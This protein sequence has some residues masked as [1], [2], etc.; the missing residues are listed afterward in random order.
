MF[1]K[2]VA[3]R[4]L[5][6]YR[7]R[8][9]RSRDA[10]PYFF[11]W[12]GWQRRILS[13]VHKQG[14]FAAAGAGPFAV[15]RL[16]RLF[17]D[18]SR[19]ILY[20]NVTNGS[21]MTTIWFPASE[22]NGGTPG[23]Y[24]NSREMLAWIELFQKYGFHWNAAQIAKLTN[25]YSYSFPEASIS[26]RPRKFPVVLYVHGQVG[27]RTDNTGLAEELASHGFIVV[28][29]AHGGTAGMELPDG[30]MVKPK[31]EFH[32]SGN[33]TNP[34]AR[35]VFR[36]QT[37]DLQFVMD[38]L[39]R[40]NAH[41]SVFAGRL[42][43]NHIGVFGW[44]Y[45]GASAAELCNVDRRCKAGVGLDPG[46]HPDLSTIRFKQPFLILA[47]PYGVSVGAQRLFEQLDKDAYFIKIR[48]ASHDEFGD[49]AGFFPHDKTACHQAIIRT[50]LVAFFTKYLKN[51]D[52]YDL[53]ALPPD[54]PEVEVFLKK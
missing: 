38:E 16:D 33:D 22:V 34:V 45:G 32:L 26:S 48:N 52:G 50:Y 36:D 31:P 11:K 9:V 5:S 2:N 25:S 44:S 10:K 18:S 24:V 30:T 29:S 13:A 54:E 14:E 42:D 19:D 20:R 27:L 51:E 12:K 41:D 3:G 46:G 53:D 43:M 17:T 15:G 1:F 47:G 40:L 35:A 6:H 4:C 7:C 37:L 23:P 8:R 28:S 21:L 39:K 49:Y